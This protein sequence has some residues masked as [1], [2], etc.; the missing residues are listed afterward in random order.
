MDNFSELVFTEIK[1]QY[2]SVRKFAME[3]GIPQTTIASALKNG[4]GGTSYDT[5]VKICKVLDIKLVNYDTPIKL[6]DD[7]IDFL[8]KYN[9]LDH[10]GSHAV[11]SLL[12][13]EYMRCIYGDYFAGKTAA[14]GGNNSEEIKVDSEEQ[15]KIQAIIRNKRKK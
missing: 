6:D 10:L 2:H 4:I 5:V 11:S 3:I 13:L 14:F 7:T 12:D 9:S 8:Q 1:K 15:K